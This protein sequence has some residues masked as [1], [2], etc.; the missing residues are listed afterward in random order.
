TTQIIAG[1]LNIRHDQIKTLRAARSRRSHILAEDHRA[2]RARWRELNHAK[3]LA[4]VEVGVEPPPEPPVKLLRAVDI[5]HRENDNFEL[6]VDLRNV[7][8]TRGCSL[9]LMG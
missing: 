7:R 3:I 4:V 5:R 8:P 1:G 9:A 6:H 2:P